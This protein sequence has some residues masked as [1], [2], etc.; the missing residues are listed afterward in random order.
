MVV[1]SVTCHPNEFHLPAVGSVI[2]VE[3][4][5]TLRESLAARLIASSLVAG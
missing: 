5:V 3:I 1:L 4:K 2:I